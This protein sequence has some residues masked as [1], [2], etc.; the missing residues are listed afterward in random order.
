MDRP[1]RMFTVILIAAAL[2]PLSCVFPFVTLPGPASDT[3]PETGALDVTIN[4]TG[5]WYVETFQYA[6]DADNIRHFVLVVPESEAERADAGWIFTS[7]TF[8][9][10]GEI[11]VREDR[12]DYAW[13][14]EYLHE[15][16]QGYFTGDFA[17][18]TYVVAAA[19]IAAP[20]SREEAEV[21]EDVLL[22]P[23]V[24]GGGASTDY[25]TVAIAAGETTFVTIQLTDENGWA[26]PWLYV[27]DGQT[28]ERRTEILRNLN[29][30]AREDT[31]IT[32]IG[33]AAVVDGYIVIRVAEEKA[34]VTTLDALALLIDGETVPAEGDPA[35]AAVD[36]VYLVLRQ[37]EARDLRFRAPDS[38][39]DSDPV[40]VIVTGYYAR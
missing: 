25:Q 9:A 3:T 6:R 12:Q 20:L 14:L 28:F 29:S 19:F 21:G 4:Y 1:R 40:S 33:P 38:F 32:P 16:P 35:L 34:E 7:L 24:T 37:G 31:E 8:E 30:P 18:G 22:W 5:S 39:K 27:F 36:G 10:D 2:L 15:A 11:G 17:P 13:G 23:G 26:C